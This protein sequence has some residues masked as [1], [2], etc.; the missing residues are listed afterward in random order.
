MRRNFRKESEGGDN[1]MLAQTPWNLQVPNLS[2]KNLYQS[3]EDRCLWVEDIDMF[4]F[5]SVIKPIIQY[6]KEDKDLPIEERKPIKLIFSSCGGDVGIMN[7]AIDVIM[8]SKTPVF[9][10]NVS[11]CYSAAAIIFLACDKRYTMPHA[12]YLIHQGSGTVNANTQQMFDMVDNL[13]EV[14]TKIKEFV[15]ERT[16]IDSKLYSKKQRKEWYIEPEKQ[17]ELG[18]CDGIIESLDELY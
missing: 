3:I 18:V 16:N 10:Y 13:K 2:V 9:G 5:E 14:E 8:A 17:I 4:T 6:N 11:Y 15:L 7:S 12:E 1:V